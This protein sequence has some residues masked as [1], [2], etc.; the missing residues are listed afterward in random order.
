MKSEGSESE[1]LRKAAPYSL[2]L[3][4]LLGLITVLASNGI[5]GFLI[6]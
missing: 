2:T 4:V 5:L 1:I 3:I 6:A